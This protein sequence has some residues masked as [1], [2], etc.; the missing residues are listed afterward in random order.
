MELL[1][2]TCPLIEL[3]NMIKTSSFFSLVDVGCSGGIDPIFKKI[4]GS[5]VQFRALGI[6]ASVDEIERLCRENT[7]QRIH[8]ID[9]IVGLE[10]GHPFIKEQEKRPLYCVDYDL[11]KRLSVYRSMLLRENYQ[12]IQTHEQKMQHNQW[13]STRLSSNLITLADTIT[14]KCFSDVDLL[15]IDIDGPDFMAIQSL[16]KRFDEFGILAVVMEINYIGSDYPTDHTFHN[17]DRFM[18]QNGFELFGLTIRPYSASSLPFRFLY[19][20]PM[21]T[22]YGRPFQ[23]DALYMRDICSTSSPV[24]NIFLTPKKLINAVL[25]FSMFG[26]PDCAAE[27]LLAHK[28][29][30]DPFF[31]ITVFLN[32]LT[33]QS[34]SMQCGTPSDIS[35]YRELMALYESDSPAFYMAIEEQKVPSEADRIVEKLRQHRIIWFFTLG[36][37]KISVKLYNILRAI[38]RKLLFCKTQKGE[39]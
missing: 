28:E 27:I 35:N 18:R 9:G 31:D 32:A 17:T 19:N 26:L 12:C 7:D 8:Y 15:K 13:Q 22:T 38:K 11:W 10:E 6:D 30:L 16:H 2:E 20:A 34:V 4:G 5:Y 24:P 21:Q 29:K 14:E 23:G 33:K 3:Y 36:A 39:Q 25:L 37:Y 1:Q